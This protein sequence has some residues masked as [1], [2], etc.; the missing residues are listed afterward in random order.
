[1]DLLQ[2]K[3]M[4]SIHLKSMHKSK[5]SCSFLLFLKI[6]ISLTMEHETKN[7]DHQTREEEVANL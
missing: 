1:M 4:V 3:V 5:K 7:E 2:I 6:K